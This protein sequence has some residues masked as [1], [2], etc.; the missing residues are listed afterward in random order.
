MWISSDHSKII[1]R[2]RKL[3]KL[4]PDQVRIIKQPEENDGCI[5]A[6]VPAEWLVITPP[7][8]VNMTEEQKLA[9]AERLRIMREM[10]AQQDVD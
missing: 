1:W 5:Y 2:V 10:K 6:T 4:Y 3:K 8:R 9:S 7:R